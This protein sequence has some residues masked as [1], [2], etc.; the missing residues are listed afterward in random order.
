MEIASKVPTSLYPSIPLAVYAVVARASY[1]PA[2]T[3]SARTPGAAYIYK[4]R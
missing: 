1:N 4:K 2:E 3:A